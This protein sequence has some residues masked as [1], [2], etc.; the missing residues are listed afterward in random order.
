MNIKYLQN[1]AK[2]S[3]IIPVYNTS[4]ELLSE[5]FNSILNQKFNDYEVILINDFSQDISTLEYIKKFSIKHKWL[6]INHN[7]NIGLGM[8]RNTGIAHS[9]GEYILFIDSDDWISENYLININNYLIKNSKYDFVSFNFF[10]VYKHAQVENKNLVWNNLGKKIYGTATA[11][12]KVYKLS[13]LNNNNILFYDTK[14]PHEDEYWFLCLLLNSNNFEA[15]NESIYFYNKI[16]SESIMNQLNGVNSLNALSKYLEFF[17]N[18]INLE[19]LNSNLIKQLIS[20]FFKPIYILINYPSIKYKDFK[21]CLFIYIKLAKLLRKKK[22][23]F[24]FLI[25]LYKFPISILIYSAAKIYRF[26]RNLFK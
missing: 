4:I 21:N 2:F 6:L 3:I 13:F 8:S 22:A 11:W 1:N 14:L 17:L 16:N 12:S 25:I 18:K 19:N 9:K 23:I 26:F 5:C 10:W 15:M 20:Y 7:S 24:Y